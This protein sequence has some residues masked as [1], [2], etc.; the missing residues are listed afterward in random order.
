MATFAEDYRERMHYRE[1]P[2][3][4]TFSLPFTR[5]IIMRTKRLSD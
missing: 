5:P 4:Y 2:A 1:A 3:Q